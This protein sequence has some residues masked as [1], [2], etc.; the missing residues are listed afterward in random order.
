[1]APSEVD[2]ADRGRADRGRATS[3]GHSET[4]MLAVTHYRRRQYFILFRP[5]FG[6]RDSY[7]C[8]RNRLRL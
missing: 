3:L 5:A 2:H 7:N 6:C 4:A 8:F 1:M